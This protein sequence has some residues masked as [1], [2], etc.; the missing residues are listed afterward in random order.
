[1]SRVLD[2]GQLVTWD[3]L[4]YQATGAGVRVY[5]RTGS[6]SA[7]GA[8]WTAWKLVGQGDRVVGGSR[9]AQY[10]VELTRSADGTSPVLHGVGITSDAK[11]LVTPGETG[12]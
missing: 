10:R 6:M 3:R 1:V 2:A 4:A 8:G 5:V 7:P 12:H 11:P 9:Y